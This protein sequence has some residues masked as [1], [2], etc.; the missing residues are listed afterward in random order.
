MTEKQKGLNLWA[1]I[2]IIWSFYRAFFKTDLPIWFDEIIMKPF[3][4]VLPVILFISKFDKKKPIT[5]LKLNIHKKLYYIFL[6]V[7]IFFLFFFTKLKSLFFYYF[8][9]SLFTAFSEEILSRGFILT[10]IY[11]ESK[12][13]FFSIL[14]SSLLSVCLHIPII[15]TNNVFSGALLIKVL[16]LDFILGIVVS[17]L[18]LEEKSLIPPILVHTVFSL[19]FYLFV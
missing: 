4:F 15:L 7:F 3:V 10:K 6:A 2:L 12:N 5:V 9:I 13:K 16:I 8:F 1:V 18:Y 19:S 14:Q 11:E 17:F